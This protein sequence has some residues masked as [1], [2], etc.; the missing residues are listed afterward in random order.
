MPMMVKLTYVLVGDCY[1]HGLM[2][3]EGMKTGEV[4]EFGSRALGCAI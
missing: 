1:V 2:R 3:L 4:Q